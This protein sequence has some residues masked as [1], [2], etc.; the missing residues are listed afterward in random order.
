[1][2]LF[3][4]II[5]LTKSALIVTAAIY[6]LVGIR[7]IR[8]SDK[9]RLNRFSLVLFA[10]ALYSVGYF[11]EIN[12]KT[13]EAMLIARNF[14][15]LGVCFIPM[16][17]IM[18][19]SDITDL[20]MP[21]W[22]TT[23]LTA[24]SVVIWLFYVTNPLHQLFHKKIEIVFIWDIA[25][26]V[27]VKGP[28]YYVLLAYFAVFLVLSIYRLAR[29]YLFTDKKSKKRSLLFLIVAF[30]IPWI[31]IFAII[32]GKDKYLDYTLFSILIMCGL[33]VI[34]ER[35]NDMFEIQ[36]KKWRNV[37]FNFGSPTF[38]ANK[39][40]V[41]IQYNIAAFKLYKERKKEIEEEIRHFGRDIQSKYIYLP[42]N[43]EIRWF[44]VRKSLFRDSKKYKNFVFVDITD[45]KNASLV[46]EAFFDTIND[47]VFI[48]SV[49][50]KLLFV[51]NAVR[52]RLG[53]A[54]D[55]LLKMSLSDFYSPKNK[56]E[57]K[58]IISRLL[59]DNEAD[60]QL[61]LMKKNGEEIFV[62]SRMWLGDWNGSS[63]IYGMS[64]D[65]TNRKILE[66]ELE[67][68]KMLLETTLYSVGDG[69][70][71]TD[72]KGNIVFMNRVAESLTGW[73][74]GEARGKFIEEVFNIYEEGSGNKG[75]NIIKRVIQERRIIDNIGNMVLLS[76][77]NVERPIEQTA[78]PIINQTGE[79][80][81]AVLVFRDYSEKREKQ[82]EIEFL[83]YHDQLTGLYNRRYFEKA[84]K[85]TGN[86]KNLPLTLVM[87]DVN[88]LKLTND[89]FGHK[90]GD[91]LLI[92]IADI[93]KKACREEDL[94]FRIGGDEFL[95]LVSKTGAG[96][97]DKLVENINRAIENKQIDNI[98]LS[99]SIGY[100]VKEKAS[101]NIDE[102]YK[103]AEDEMYRNKLSESSSMRS[104]TI[105]LIMNTLYEKNKR[106]MF[107]SLR[108][109]AL[110]EKAAA[111]MG[112][113]KDEIKQLKIAGLMHDIGKIGIS[114]RILNKP[115]TLDSEERAEIMRHSEIGY[116][117]LSSVNE[118]SE[119]ADIVLAHHER[120]DGTGYPRG[121]KGENIPLKARIVAVADVYD[122][123]TNIR[124]Y[125]KVMTK[126]EAIKELFDGAGTQFDPEVV[127]A[128]IKI[129]DTFN[130]QD[131]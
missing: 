16:F 119:I 51:N 84:L 33:F 128:F 123:I 121:V 27:T 30:M 66:N 131:E 88:G 129:L 10:V 83:S 87:V 52:K 93:L 76:K 9:N 45:K 114:E 37:F 98:I 57:H 6:V 77:F 14:E 26:A 4:I 34:N 41:I 78:A 80:S 13:Y 1:M 91:K 110:C 73:R 107:H 17:G 65:I 74:L 89:A 19:I 102:I 42:V 120:W 108:V 118:F 24:V 2:D 92:H 100:A 53:Y 81:G 116:R 64:Q 32:F 104:R 3:K 11:F 90:M 44:E 103:K 125:G 99:A 38:L 29:A 75:E 15:Y 115:G 22:E 12:S 49:E 67:K 105:D 36:V 31:N 58:K 70:I 7:L 21:R 50:E 35:R 69:V 8:Q 95:L 63:V 39:D 94:A 40:N 54:D 46:A 18:F 59:A 71:S 68:E 124:S 82:K 47:F 112:F 20:R 25:A 43:D 72:K 96:E 55:E 85:Q 23:L 122:A 106:E 130:E 126:E 48:A 97:A 117:I 109:G 79:S 5:D 86:A 60:F 111:Y 56:D 127:N 62:E 101:E 113:D 28:L 61:P